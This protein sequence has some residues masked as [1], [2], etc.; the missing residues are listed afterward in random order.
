ML[1]EFNID[2]IALTDRGRKEDV[3]RKFEHATEIQQRVVKSIK[4]EDELTMGEILNN[5][6]KPFLCTESKLTQNFLNTNKLALIYK[7]P[8]HFKGTLA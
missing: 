2:Q 4:K 8:K 3:R 6:L 7:M 1:S 5:I